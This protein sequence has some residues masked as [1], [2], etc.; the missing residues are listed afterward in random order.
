MV[1]AFIN[2]GEASATKFCYLVSLHSKVSK[3]LEKIVNN[4]VRRNR[5]WFVIHNEVFNIHN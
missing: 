3:N 4:R 5:L 2:I 1:P